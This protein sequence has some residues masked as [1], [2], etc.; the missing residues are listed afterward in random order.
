MPETPPKSVKFQEK[1]GCFLCGREEANS[2]KRRSL[3]QNELLEKVCQLLPV[4]SDL[5]KINSH[6]YVCETPC[7]RDLEKFFKLKA[8]IETLRNSMLKRFEGAQQRSKRC[9]PSDV[10]PHQSPDPK[11]Q[12]RVGLSD[13]CV[14]R[15]LNF[16]LAVG[17][18]EK[19][20]NVEDKEAK[21]PQPSPHPT[22]QRLLGPWPLSSVAK[23]L[24]PGFLFCHKPLY[25]LSPTEELNNANDDSVTVQVSFS[26]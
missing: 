1:D 21:T 7:Y 14:A 26:A 13:G 16:G 4:T 12:S 22:V 8:N 19:I 25:E 9:L 20:T 2:R 3:A 6:R 10:T 24:S 15:S 11:R 5:L 17:S 18:C 23:T